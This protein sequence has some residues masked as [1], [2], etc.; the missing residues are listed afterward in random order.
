MTNK[1]EA[2]ERLAELRRTG[3]LTDEE[4]VHEKRQIIEAF[5]QR[6]E[7][8]AKRGLKLGVW[9]VTAV[10]FA[11][12]I[13]IAVSFYVAKGTNS[14][15]LVTPPPVK[16]LASTKALPSDLVIT[17]ALLSDPPDYETLINTAVQIA[18]CPGKE[19]SISNGASRR[20]NLDSVPDSSDAFATLGTIE[21]GGRMVF[22]ADE[23][24]G[25]YHVRDIDLQKSILTY[26]VKD[27][28]GVARRSVVQP[29]AT[30]VSAVSQNDVYDEGTPAMLRGYCVFKLQG[31]DLINGPC[32]YLMESDGSFRFANNQNMSDVWGMVNVDGQSGMAHWNGG[33]GASH[34]HNDI[35]EVTRDGACWQN[36]VSRICV[37]A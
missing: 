5:E 19:L 15:P 17:N 3:M 14:D 27:C 33:D 37:R 10:I 25:L 2:L 4:Y 20:V 16:P 6:N 30:M 34:A 35:G 23:Y 21:P 24:P 11:I 31:R 12:L 32:Y 18:V 26:E 28:S 8:P 22:E 13:G 36:D 9:I 1:I 29:K 7:N